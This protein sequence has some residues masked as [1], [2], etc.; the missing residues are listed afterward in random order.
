MKSNSLITYIIYALL[1]GLILVAGYKACQIRQEQTQRQKENAEL[2]QVM[3]DLGYSN[4]STASGSSYLGS[5]DST[6]KKSPAT[7]TPT[8]GKPSATTQAQPKVSA[9]GIEDESPKPQSAQP[10]KPTTTQATKPAVTQTV[11]PV[12]T[13]PTTTAKS[14]NLSGN[15]PNYSGKYMV[16]TGAFKQVENARDEME[17]LVKAGYRN[18]EVKKFT[19]AWAHVIALRTN[20]KAAAEKAVAKLKTEGYPGAYVKKQ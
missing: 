8:T 2:D 4:D 10:A 19:S 5:S 18:A 13:Q 7:S 1:L 20:D 6:A 14:P 11:K 17:T 9:T 16:V 3:R 15:T 12:V